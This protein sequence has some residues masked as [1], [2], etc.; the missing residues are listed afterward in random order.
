M[1]QET[2]KDLAKIIGRYARDPV[3]ARQLQRLKVFTLPADSTAVFQGLLEKLEQRER[4]GS[5]GYA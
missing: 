3:V 1:T 4:A 5:A 2:E